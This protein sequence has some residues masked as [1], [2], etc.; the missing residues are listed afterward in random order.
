MCAS[1]LKRRSFLQV[2]VQHPHHRRRFGV[3]F[4]V[5]AAGGAAAAELQKAAGAGDAHVQQA[6][7]LGNVVGV[8]YAR[9]RNLH[10]LNAIDHIV[11][12]VNGVHECKP[13]DPLADVMNILLAKNQPCV[14]EAGSG[15]VEKVRIMGTQHAPLPGCLLKMVH[16]IFAKQA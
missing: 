5:G 11:R 9:F 4:F 2:A 1:G 3:A 12:R 10:K 15:E 14:L 8:G 13:V 16:I 6:Q 7:L